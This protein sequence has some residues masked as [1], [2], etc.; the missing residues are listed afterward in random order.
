MAETVLFINVDYLKNRR[1]E[2]NE[3]VNAGAFETAIRIAEDLDIF[4]LLGSGLYSQIKDQIANGD[5]SP[6]NETLLNEYIAPAL[7]EYSYARGLMGNHFKITAKGVQT[8]SADFSEAAE[9]SNLKQLIADAQAVAGQYGDRLVR[10]LCENS[11]QYP[12]YM[13]PGTGATAQSPSGSAIN[14]AGGIWLGTKSNNKDITPSKRG[15]D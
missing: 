13:N 10:Y 11:T 6:V 14:N 4:S 3:N 12:L 9:M 15:N 2:I 8:R 5:L 1:R 7:A